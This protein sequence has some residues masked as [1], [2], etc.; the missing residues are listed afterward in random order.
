MITQL[1]LS[2]SLAGNSVGVLDL[3]LTGPSIPR[4]FAV[5]SEKVTQTPGGWLPIIVHAGI[6]TE[7]GKI[8]SLQVMSLGF[9]LADRGVGPIRPPWY[10]SF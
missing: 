7:N 1:A 6:E 10:N 4:M 5:E 2:L 9:L 8:G 3:N